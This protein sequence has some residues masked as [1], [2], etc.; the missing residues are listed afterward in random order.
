MHLNT[1]CKN[2]T[3]PESSLIQIQLNKATCQLINVNYVCVSMIS[4]ESSWLRT[5]HIHCNEIITHSIHQS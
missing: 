1:V 4:H 3:P 5:P 2:L